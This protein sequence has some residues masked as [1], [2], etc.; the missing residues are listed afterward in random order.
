MNKIKTIHFVGVKGVGM[1]PLA[2]IAKEAGFTV[3]V[4][5]LMKNLLQMSP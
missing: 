1:A 4:A 5:I 3:P 2:I